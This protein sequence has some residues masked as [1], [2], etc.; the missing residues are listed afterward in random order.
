MTNFLDAIG[1][2]FQ[3]GEVPMR[4]QPSIVKLGEGEELVMDTGPDRPAMTHGPQGM[5]GDTYGGGD[6]PSPDQMRPTPEETMDAHRE[7]YAMPNPMMMQEELANAM[8]PNGPDEGELA[9]ELNVP[10]IAPELNETVQELAGQDGVPVPE[11]YEGYEDDSGKRKIRPITQD[12]DGVPPVVPKGLSPRKG[13]EDWRAKNV[14]GADSQDRPLTPE[15]AAEVDEAIEG[16]PKAPDPDKPPSVDNAPPARIKTPDGE[17]RD[18]TQEDVK[19]VAEE[20]PT[21]FAKAMSWVK[22]AFGVTGQDLAKFAALYAGSRLA[23]YDHQGSMSWSFEVAG[24]DLQERRRLHTTIANTGKYTPASLEEYNKTGDFS[25]LTAIKD[26]KNGIKIDFTSAMLTRKGDRVVYPATLANGDKVYVDAKGNRHHG[27]V[28]DPEDDETNR[29]IYE[30]YE[31][32]VVAIG[33]EYTTPGKGK[34]GKTLPEWYTGS[35]TADAALATEFAL[36]WANDNGI[37]PNS[38][39][40]GGIV[41]GAWEQARRWAQ[42]SGKEVKSIQP[43]LDQQ[44]VYVTSNDAWAGALKNKDGSKLDVEQ[45]GQVSNSVMTVLQQDPEFSTYA[46]RADQGT[47]VAWAMKALY[48]DFEALPKEQRAT[49]DKQGGFKAFLQEATLNPFDN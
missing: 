24:S 44:K 18:V 29:E 40:F 12:G 31:P 25:K 20:D 4:K 49:Y 19:S 26:P 8:M 16:M 11:G 39:A 43:F 35:E 3:F 36:Q 17:D 46:K 2:I 45:F 34:D 9:P 14:A 21:G 42:S 5:F 30:E 27:F 10:R 32:K 1:N 22:N 41:S 15:Q 33:K 6:M 7:S 48:S 38:A 47:M 23:G 37:P 28:K 13:N